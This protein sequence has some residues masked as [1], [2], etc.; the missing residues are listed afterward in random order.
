MLLAGFHVDQLDRF[1]DRT[2][3]GAELESPQRSVADGVERVVFDEQSLGAVFRTVGHVNRADG[4]P[5]SIIDQLPDVAAAGD[6]DSAASVDRHSVDVVGEIIAGELGDDK[7]RRQ[8]ESRNLPH[9][10]SN[11]AQ[12]EQ[13]NTD[14]NS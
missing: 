4:F 5:V 11:D 10:W 14:R 12:A 2:T 7:S 6:E 9:H 8:R 13:N 1:A 3:I